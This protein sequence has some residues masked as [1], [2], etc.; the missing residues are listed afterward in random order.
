MILPRRFRTFEPSKSRRDLETAA[1]TIV[2]GM[3]CLA[4]WAFG[5]VPAWAQLALHAGTA[6]VTILVVIADGTTPRARRVLCL[7]SL[8]LAGLILL[9]LFQATPLPGGVLRLLSPASAS[10]RSG[11]LP[12]APE[13]VLGDP[14]PLVSLPPFRLSQDADATIQTAAALAATWLLFQG[15]L[16]LGG[17]AANIRRLAVAFS[18]N[19]TLLALFSIVQALTWNGR[20]Y[21]SALRRRPTPGPGAARSSVTRIWRNT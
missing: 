2:V 9:A 21:G 13:R 17:D 7:P 18:L 4:P 20:I 3:A 6:A 1:E 15:V 11:L 8:G 5:S 19:A 12:P 10:L 14:G 16:G